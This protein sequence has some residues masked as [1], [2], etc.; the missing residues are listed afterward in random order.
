MNLTEHV[1]TEVLSGPYQC[2]P[3]T[4]WFVHVM[5]NSWGCVR[6]GTVMTKTYEEALAVGK[7]Y[8]YDA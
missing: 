2:E 6:E 7:G 4:Y 8:T 3:Y 5:A 1:V